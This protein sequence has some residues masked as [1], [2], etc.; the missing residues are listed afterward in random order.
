M[1]VIDK[2]KKGDSVGVGDEM[3]E[4]TGKPFTK[5]DRRQV[6]REE[7]ISINIEEAEKGGEKNKG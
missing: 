1:G 4:Y 6:K 5:S 7:E 2:I 3:K